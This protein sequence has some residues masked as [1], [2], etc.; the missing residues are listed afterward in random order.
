LSDWVA[1][2]AISDGGVVCPLFVV[3]V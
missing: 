3:P 1:G 2:A